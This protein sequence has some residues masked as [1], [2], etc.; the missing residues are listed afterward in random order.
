MRAAMQGVLGAGEESFYLAIS[1][2]ALTGK[3]FLSAYLAQ[4]HPGAA[5]AYAGMSL[6]TKVVRF[7]VQNDKLYVLRADDHKAWSDTFDPTIIVDA[8]PIVDKV[9]ASFSDKAG[10]Y[11]L[12]DP[13]A[14]AHRD[15]ALPAT[16]VQQ[17]HAGL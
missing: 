15:R 3:Y 5:T 13:A 16:T 12:V 8:F 6:G 14:G 17:P 4:V 11:I 10:R 7:A 2:S 1:K 9:P